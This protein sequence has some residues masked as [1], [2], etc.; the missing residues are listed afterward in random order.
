[1]CFLSNL[2]SLHYIELPKGEEEKAK[3]NKAKSGFELTALN[4]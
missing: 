4:V 3:K 2:T 1:M